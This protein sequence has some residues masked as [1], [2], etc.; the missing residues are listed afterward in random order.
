MDINYQITTK[1]ATV[2]ESK[3]FHQLNTPYLTTRSLILTRGFCCVACP[4]APPFL[5]TPFF[6]LCCTV[7]FLIWLDVS[8]VKNTVGNRSIK[9]VRAGSGSGRFQTGPNSKFKFEFKKI[10]NS[11]K[12]P[13][14]TSSCDESN[15]VKFFSN[16]RSFSILWE[17]LKLNRKKHAYK[18][19]QIQC[20]ICKSSTK[21]GWRVHL[22]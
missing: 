18:S 17:H 1:C 16:I 10:E 8:R 2:S 4:S 22:G 14:N 15:G 5:P 6:P 21:E 20:K 12:N 11:K 3:L 13:K 19:I 7:T 9:L